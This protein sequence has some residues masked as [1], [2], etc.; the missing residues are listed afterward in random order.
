MICASACYNVRNHEVTELLST[1]IADLV[2]GEF[3]QM[4][5]SGNDGEQDCRVAS[6]FEYYMKK[7]YLKTA[8]LIGFI[9]YSLSYIL[10]RRC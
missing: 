3:F 6:D 10:N 5:S 2:E 7:T 8:S 1:V 9:F 4:R